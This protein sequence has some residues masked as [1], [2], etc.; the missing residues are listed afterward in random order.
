MMEYDIHTVLDALTLSATVCIVLAMMFTSLKQ[1]YQ[2]DQDR[3][4]F[5][6]VVRDPGR[7]RA[8]LGELAC[9]RVLFLG[10]GGWR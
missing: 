7:A 2:K 9:M 6:Y 5:F 3:V 8:I 10:V 1:S 4:K